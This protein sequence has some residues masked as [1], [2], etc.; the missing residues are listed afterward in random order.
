MNTL[1]K[2][3][4]KEIIDVVK[5][6]DVKVIFVEKKP[7]GD[8]SQYKADYFIL[9]FETG[10]KE[11]ITK[12]AYLLKKFGSNYRKITEVLANFV[13]CDAYCTPSKNV[14]A[15]F[16]NG[17]AGMFDQLGNMQ[18]NG[19]L[20]YN[21]KTVTSMA[22]DGEYFWTCCKDENCVIR[23]NCDNIKV[24]IRIGGKDATTFSK[25]NF[26]SSDDDYIYVCCD[27][28]K[29]RKIDKSNFTV[30]DIDATYEDLTKFYKL[31]RF[32][33]ICTKNGAYID[34]D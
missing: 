15:I 4:N 7:F 10:K 20:N 26:I 8:L 16:P 29:V 34:K 27:N 18:W 14:L 30:T 28:S 17:Q 31:G 1:L 12:N 19:T 6:S 24:D 25:P 5:Y 22:G 11:V 13:Q 3:S 21:D 23:Y 32:S 33:I 2:I 9:N